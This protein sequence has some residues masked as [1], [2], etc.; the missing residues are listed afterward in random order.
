VTGHERVGHAADGGGA[1]QDAGGVTGHGGGAEGVEGVDRFVVGVVV[2]GGGRVLERGR[3]GRK[4]YVLD[5]AL[6]TG[7][8][9]DVADLPG[10]EAVQ[11]GDLSCEGAE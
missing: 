5:V 8:D 7:G 1:G 9:V 3:A 4:D 10:G 2:E 6:A 11:G